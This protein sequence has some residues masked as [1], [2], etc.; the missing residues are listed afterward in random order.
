MLGGVLERHPKLRVALLESGVGWVP[1]FFERMDEHLE[2]RGRLT[3]ECKHEPRGVHRA[4]PALR[5]LRAGGAA[6]P[7]AVE[8]LGADFI[9]YASDYPHWDSDFPNSTQAAARAHGHLAPP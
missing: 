4:R 3:P 1:Y 8:A 6:V 7:F 9:M 5:Q 2:K